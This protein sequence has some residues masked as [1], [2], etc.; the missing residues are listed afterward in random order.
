MRVC[1]PRGR[2]R[3]AVGP[4]FLAWWYPGHFLAG[5]RLLGPFWGSSD[6]LHS[7]LTLMATVLGDSLF[8]SAVAPFC[9]AV[10]AACGM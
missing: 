2:T 3:T 7:S 6:E 10:D 8:F 5:K 1:V 4:F 9:S